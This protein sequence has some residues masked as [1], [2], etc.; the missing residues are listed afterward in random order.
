[1]N[2]TYP[3]GYKIND[4]N[5]LA[6]YHDQSY[7]ESLLV[8]DLNY[9]VIRT[10]RNGKY[11]SYIQ[12]NRL[13]YLSDTFLELENNKVKY[14]EKHD[15]GYGI[16]QPI[17]YTVLTVLQKSTKQESK[18]DGLGYLLD[19]KADVTEAAPDFVS[20]I[21]DL[22]LDNDLRADFKYYIKNH[23]DIPVNK[24]KYSL[25]GSLF[26]SVFCSYYNEKI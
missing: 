1:M 14:I 19:Y 9:I 21:D 4:E 6:F 7:D 22:Y 11:P 10:L 20:Y 17:L 3:N 23:S 5:F 16:F 2:I 15:S 25:L 8:R 26:Y 24:H 13:D 18:Y 12:I